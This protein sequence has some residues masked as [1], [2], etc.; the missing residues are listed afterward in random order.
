MKIRWEAAVK[1]L[2]RL[3]VLSNKFIGFLEVTSSDKIENQR[4][5]RNVGNKIKVL[6]IPFGDILIG[7]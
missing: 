2:E 7:S 1:L 6:D 4:P 3:L 5:A